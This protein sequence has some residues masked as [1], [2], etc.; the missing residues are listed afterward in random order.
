MKSPIY[1]F[2]KIIMSCILSKKLKLKHILD[3]FNHPSNDQLYSLLKSMIEPNS[4]NRPT[5]IQIYD[6]FTKLL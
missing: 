2:I 3:F 5:I 6:I 4:N 1:T